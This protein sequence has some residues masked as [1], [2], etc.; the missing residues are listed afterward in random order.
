[1]TGLALI[2]CTVAGCATAPAAPGPAPAG[3]RLDAPVVHP[4]TA[5]LEVTGTGRVSVEPGIAALTFAVESE[6]RTA[7][8]AVRANADAMQ[9]TMDALRNARDDLR[10]ETHGYSVN[11]RYS[12]P[13][14]SGGATRI[15]GYTTVNNIRVTTERI[16]DVG[17]LID[18]A[19]GA[20]ANRVAGLRFFPTDVDGARREAL[21]R[22]VASARLEAETIAEALGVE[23]GPPLEVRGG[24]SAPSPRAERMMATAADTPIEAG[25][26]TVRATVTIRYGLG[27]A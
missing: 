6:G 13:G 2:L 26:Q 21:R 22:A 8:E 3:H 24:A 20:G 10:I 9:S 1:M 11:P 18:A 25:A 7:Q 16:D 4:D 23:L 5:F 19:T 12:R 27:G 15:D 14:P 17:A